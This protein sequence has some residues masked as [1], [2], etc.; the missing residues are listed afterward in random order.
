MASLAPLVATGTSPQSHLRFA[1]A[2]LE[3]L[4]RRDP[5]GR[6][7]RESMSSPRRRCW[8]LTRC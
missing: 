8:P 4:R 5:D 6:L 2:L 3:E 7:S 1:A